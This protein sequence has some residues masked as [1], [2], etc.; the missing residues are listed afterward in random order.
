MLGNP[1]LLPMQARNKCRPCWMV[2]C[3]M[4]LYIEVK[5]DC[6]SM[7]LNHPDVAPDRMDLLA[8]TCAHD[9][10]DHV[11]VEGG[12]KEPEVLPLVIVGAKLG[13]TL[14]RAR[15]IEAQ[16]LQELRVRSTGDNFVGG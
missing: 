14:E 16:A 10:A 8:D 7:K 5:G 2:R 12:G 9:V 4:H 3:R 1:D 11:D 6:G 13:L 15:Q